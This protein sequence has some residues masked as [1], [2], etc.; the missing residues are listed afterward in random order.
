MLQANAEFC[1]NYT[2]FH[3]MS[4]RVHFPIAEETSFDIISGNF[5]SLSMRTLFV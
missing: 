4:D 3:L 5:A 1:S 2:A